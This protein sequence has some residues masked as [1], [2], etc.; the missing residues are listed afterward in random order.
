MLLARWRREGWHIHMAGLCAPS[1]RRLL[2]LIFLFAAAGEC[3]RRGLVGR[4]LLDVTL[5]RRCFS[6]AKVQQL[7]RLQL[8][9]GLLLCVV[10]RLLPGAT[11]AT[12]RLAAD[13]R[14]NGSHTEVSVQCATAC[15]AAARVQV[16]LCKRAART[17]ARV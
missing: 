11:A 6:V 10:Q 13:K 3:R 16:S 17:M 8:H 2:L 15:A 9:R 12:A 14:H 5:E 1:I 4:L 7:L